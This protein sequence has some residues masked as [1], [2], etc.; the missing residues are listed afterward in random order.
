MKDRGDKVFDLRIR[1][2]DYSRGDIPYS[3]NGVKYFEK[4]CSSTSRQ[5]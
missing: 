1:K 2:V 3:H 4:N 5:I